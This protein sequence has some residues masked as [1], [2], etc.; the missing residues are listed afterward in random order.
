MYREAAQTLMLSGF[1]ALSAAPALAA[2]AEP[3]GDEVVQPIA[4]V[5]K[6][7]PSKP[8]WCEG[9]KGQLK[10]YSSMPVGSIKRD[11][12]YDGYLPRTMR[13]IA[14]AACDAP[15][16]PVR[17]KWVAAWRQ[18]HV[19]QT[20]F[21]EK[22]DRE[23]MKLWVLSQAEYEAKQKEVCDQFVSSEETLLPDRYFNRAYR[24]IFGCD[25]SSDTNLER[26]NWWYD[27][28]AEAPNELL[29][30]WFVATC[31]PESA[32]LERS[33]GRLAMCGPDARRL[34][35][36]QM[37][38]D[39]E[40]LKVGE[41]GKVHA[42]AFLHASRKLAQRFVGFYEE[43]A[44]K[45]PAYKEILFEAP[46]KGFVAWTEK[47]AKNKE[48]M[49]AAIALE[50][51][52]TTGSKKALQGCSEPM[53]K[54]LAAYLKG[55]QPKTLDDV[56]RLAND[57]VG[58]MLTSALVVCYAYEERFLEAAETYNLMKTSRVE[59]GPRT[60]AYYQA[61]SKLN[62]VLADQER[63]PLDPRW[64]YAPV[65]DVGGDREAWTYQ[66][67]EKTFNQ[68]SFGNSEGKVKD[69]KP[70]GTGVLL[71]FQTAT[72]NEPVYDC[73]ETNRIDRITADGQ[74]VYR[75][76]CNPAGTKKVSQ[77]PQPALLPKEM[78]ESIKKGMMVKLT[79]NQNKQP[80]FGFP[81]AVFQDQ[82]Q[83]QLVSSYG[84]SVK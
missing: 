83:K 20:G 18:G 66:A 64:F 7:A 39:L 79:T 26:F 52:W 50:N 72:W 1:L 21:T 19:N 34:D 10:E 63:F 69:A 61:M 46:E 43:K 3:Q 8:D 67:Y 24:D 36:A 28:K 29:R 60:S 81:V 71:T 15:D 68:I 2:D 13:K 53:R 59:R 77:T 31:L 22:Q 65:P 47:Y 44:K 57:E 6:I 23:A 74:V 4:G 49:E 80:H 55:Q 76:I 17:Q 73:K 33:P 41:Y 11:L 58:Y 40:A 51:K 45:N 84:M 30:A 62:E 32:T 70:Q 16:D 27:R 12:G 37:E 42:R 38:K 48:A 35:A 78:A 14:W 56:T 75:Q 82:D 54:S 5:E 9:Y 25:D